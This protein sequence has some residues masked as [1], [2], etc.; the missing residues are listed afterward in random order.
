MSQ[1][2]VPSTVVKD[3][4]K[5][6][7]SERAATFDEAPNHHWQ[8]EQQH[9]AWLEL[10]GDIAGPT[11]I[12]VLDL[13][14]G[15]GF[16]SLQLAELG[17]RV[18]GTDIAPQMVMNAEKKRDAQESTATFRLGDI[19][20]LPDADNSADLIVGR[21]IIWTLPNPFEA[22]ADWFRILR[23]GGQ[24][25]LFEF[26]G[27]ASTEKAEDKPDAQPRPAAPGYEDVAEYLPFYGGSTSDRV[28]DAF[29]DAG[30]TRVTAKSLHDEILWGMEVKNDRYVVIGR[31]PEAE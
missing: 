26:A 25:A 4:V 30:F 29:T 5:S 3:F 20:Q 14:S 18:I 24:L 23:P 6:Y 1:S 12:D 2:S 9:R 22:L 13:G 31:K 27:R 28:I 8:T 16:L 11:P 15:T 10:L 19:E 17:H 21:H 7:W